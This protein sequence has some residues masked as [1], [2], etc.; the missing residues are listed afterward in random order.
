MSPRTKEQIDKIK[1][2]RKTQITEV[3]LQLFATN[4]YNPTSIDQIANAAGI[5]KGLVY[6]Y[7]DSKENLL[8][9]AFDQGFKEIDQTIA[10]A[11]RTDSKEYLKHILNTYFE[12]LKDRF[13]Y[14]KLLMEVSLNVNQF[15]F[16]KDYVAQRY[17]EYYQLMTRLLLEIDFPQPEQEAKLLTALFDGIGIQ[18]LI[19]PDTYPLETYRKILINKYCQ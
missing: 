1:A 15:P 17:Q 12:L 7:F 4:G 10:E 9:E 11:D 3:A 6:N 5:S 2:E 19:M 13:L 14:Y 16:Y 18:Y 8:R